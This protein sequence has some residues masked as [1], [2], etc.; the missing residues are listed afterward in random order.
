MRRAIGGVSG[1]PVRRERRAR[2]DGGDGCDEK[3]KAREKEMGKSGKRTD[4]MADAR[5]KPDEMMMF[6][7][8]TAMASSAFD[9]FGHL[10]ISRGRRAF[11]R[12]SPQTRCP[13]DNPAISH[14]SRR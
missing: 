7:V 3:M 1:L 14:L 13:F 4:G 8:A 5:G 2:V 9:Y 10:P 12:N 6:G 11:F